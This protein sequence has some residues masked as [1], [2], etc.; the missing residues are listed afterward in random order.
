MIPLDLLSALFGIAIILVIKIIRFID[1][2]VFSIGDMVASFF[3][4]ALIP[5]AF[6]YILSPFFD[7]SSYISFD[8]K[9]PIYSVLMGLVL[10]FYLGSYLW[11][12]INQKRNPV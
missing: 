6:F 12:E 1:H 11:T 3:I 7:V 4:G 2:M 10:V 8:T 5:V 9:N